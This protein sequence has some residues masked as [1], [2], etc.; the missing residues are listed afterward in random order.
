MQFRHFTL[1]VSESKHGMR[2]GDYAYRKNL[3]PFAYNMLNS[4]AKFADKRH[5]D[6]PCAWC[7]VPVTL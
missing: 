1:P 6:R 2:L 3:F 5:I 7:H 4:R